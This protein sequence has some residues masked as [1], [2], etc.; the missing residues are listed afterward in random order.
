M[1]EWGEF[2]SVDLGSATVHRSRQGKRRMHAQRGVSS[3]SRIDRLSEMKHNAC[4]A[5]KRPSGVQ[6]DWF[7]RNVIGFGHLLDRGRR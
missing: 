5:R 1:S 2:K 6:V 4:P 7:V 3:E